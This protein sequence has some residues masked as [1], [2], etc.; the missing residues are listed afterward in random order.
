MKKKIFIKIKCTAYRVLEF[1]TL[2]DNDLADIL[3]F[4]RSTTS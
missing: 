1:I 2:D 3:K 4:V